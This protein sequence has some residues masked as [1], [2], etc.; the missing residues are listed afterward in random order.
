MREDVKAVLFDLDGVLVDSEPAYAAFWTAV[1]HEYFPHDA[2]FAPRLRGQTLKYIF[3]TYFPEDSAT[4]QQIAAQLAA[5]ERGMDYPLT[6][7]AAELVD[8]LSGAGVRAAVVTSSDRRKMARLYAC[9]PHF[10]WLFDCIF[11]AEDS[12]SSKPAPDC[13]LCAA[14][15]LGVEPRNCIVV[16]DSING[17]LAGRAAGMHVIGIT[18]SHKREEIA[19]LCDCVV[20]DF[21]ELSRLFSSIIHKS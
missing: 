6:E 20:D 11:T 15:G 8:A 14:A 3:D 21:M 4:Q 13:Y 10:L 16:E 9:H 7:G 12:P 5:H 19:P 1:G 17:I 2:D 18:T